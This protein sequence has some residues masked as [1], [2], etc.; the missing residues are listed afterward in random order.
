VLLNADVCH[1]Y[2]RILEAGNE[3]HWAWVAHGR[4]NSMFAQEPPKLSEEEERACLRDIF[5]VIQR[6]TG[7]RPKGWL[8]PLG[9][10]ETY[11]T[12]RLLAK[13]GAT[14]VLDWANDDQPYPLKTGQGRLLSVPYSFIR[15]AF[16]AF[17]DL[18]S[19][20]NS[21]NRQNTQGYGCTGSISARINGGSD[22][23]G[24]GASRTLT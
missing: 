12:P 20:R 1:E 15:S 23:A 5:E 21:R 24:W 9:L 18:G 6:A 7:S 10:A 4:N 16:M 19:R 14:Y 17:Y 13:L 3:R 11:A 2:P 8:G 22:R